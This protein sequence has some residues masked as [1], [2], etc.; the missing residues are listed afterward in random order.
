MLTAPVFSKCA[1]NVLGCAAAIAAIFVGAGP[2]RA[3]SV[4]KSPN[5]QMADEL[6]KYPG[7]M[8]EFGKLFQRMMTEVKYPDGRKQSSLLPVLPESTMTYVAASNYGE[9]AR[10]ILKIFREE[11]RES[12]PLRKWWGSGEVATAGPKV[13]AFLQRFSELEEYLGNETVLAGTLE[14]KDPKFFVVAE[15]RKQAAGLQV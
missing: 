1:R 4:A 7:L 3:Q 2:C 11:L 8:E 15:T 14:G 13:E 6:N 5:A 10:Q 12:E 9:P